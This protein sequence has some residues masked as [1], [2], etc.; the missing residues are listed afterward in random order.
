MCDTGAGDGANPE[1][2]RPTPMDFKVL[3]VAFN[4][5]L[6]EILVNVRDLIV[7]LSIYTFLHLTP[8]N[9][10]LLYIL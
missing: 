3:G 1:I 6:I 8:L 7:I 10:K 9:F 2:E 5:R 4:L